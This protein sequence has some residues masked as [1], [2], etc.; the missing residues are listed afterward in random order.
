[1]L[2]VMHFCCFDLLSISLAHLAHVSIPP[3][4]ALPLPGPAWTIVECFKI[5]HA[6]PSLCSKAPTGMV[7]AVTVYDWRE[8][9]LPASVH[10]YPGVSQVPGVRISRR[11][12]A[13][14]ARTK[15]VEIAPPTETPLAPA[16][17]FTIY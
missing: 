2:D 4:D 11:G 3:K 1:M 6:V 12:R 16:A 5:N 17:L 9:V 15:G 10:L 8:V 13:V 14:P 7:S